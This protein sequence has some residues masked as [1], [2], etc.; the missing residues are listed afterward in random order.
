MAWH[1]TGPSHYLNQWWLIGDWA[2]GNKLK[3]FFFYK[4]TLK[5]SLKKM[6]LNVCEKL[7]TLLR[8]QYVKVPFHHCHPYSVCMPVTL[9]KIHHKF[10]VVKSNF[11][12]FSNILQHLHICKHHSS[13]LHHQHFIFIPFLDFSR[14]ANKNNLNHISQ[15]I[16][17]MH[18]L[19]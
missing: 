6:H 11:E 10:W 16:W 19:F 12:A 13:F 17:I 7:S 14:C 18:I 1:W 3:G 2:I 8:H 15:R 9:G 5:F 4:K